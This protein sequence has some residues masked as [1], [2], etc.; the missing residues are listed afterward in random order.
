MVETGISW[1]DSA[2]EI[3]E[4]D[5]SEISNAFTI[6]QDTID[7]LIGVIESDPDKITRKELENCI[8]WHQESPF[9]FNDDWYVRADHLR[10][11]LP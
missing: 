9:E 1:A 5:T 7:T 3:F 10:K 8:D 11:L 4:M 6:L 2:A